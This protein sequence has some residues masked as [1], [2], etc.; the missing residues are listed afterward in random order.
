MERISTD[1]L[2]E[3]FTEIF[4]KD[5]SIAISDTRVYKDYIPS[6]AINLEIKPGDQI[7]K[8]SATYKAL[9]LKRKIF[10]YVD[11]N[12][13]G[14]SY[15][16]L[17]VPILE[18]GKPDRVVTAIFPTRVNFSLPKIFTIKNGDRWY[19]VP[20]QNIL[21][22]EAENRKAKIVTKNVE[23]YHKLNLSEIEYLLP[24]DYFIRCH[25]SFIVNV[26]AIAEIQ[27]DFHSTFLLV[28]NNGDR[29]PV[30]QSYASYFRKQLMF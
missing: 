24:A 2:L 12:V 15:F 19:P 13:F 9:S 8:G 17:S 29:I 26:N 16:G 18:K 14:V 4:P 1:Q 6:P 3:I 11:P 21:Y 25:R 10:S 23:G 22:L 7:K 30:S 5:T 20:V 27:P 28:M